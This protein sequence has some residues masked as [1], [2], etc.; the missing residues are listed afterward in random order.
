MPIG[1]LALQ[2]AVEPHAEKLSRLKVE[3]C[4]VRYADQLSKLKGLII[5]GGESTTLIKLI[6]I[7]GLWDPLA[8]FGRPIWGL[9]AGLILL[10]KHVTNPDQR[11]LGLLDVSV[12]RNAYGRQIDSFIDVVKPT[13][14]W[15]YERESK[16]GVFIRAPKI[17]SV[18]GQCQTLFEHENEPVLVRERSVLGGTFHPE[19]SQDD[20]IHRYFIGMCKSN[21]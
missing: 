1:I 21:G 8:R 17:T 18:G 11:S 9:C 19:L 4:P 2:G 10:A 7:N 20:A 5:P 14:A 3:W 6:E 16:E 13:D 15:D 12:S